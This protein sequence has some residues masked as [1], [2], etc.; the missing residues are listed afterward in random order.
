MPFPLGA[1]VTAQE[2][3]LD[4][5]PALARLRAAEP[6]SW[7]PA[8]DGWLITRRD[9][10]LAVMRD[11]EHF[12][13]DDPRFTTGR[14]VGPSMLT[15]DGDEH[16]RHRE[17]FAAPFRRAAVRERFAGFVARETDR[18]LDELEPAGNGE[19]RRGLAGPLAAAV[20]LH[21]LGLDETDAGAVLGWYDAIV[22]AVTEL[23]AGHELPPAGRDA[24]A[25]LA[26]ALDP[27]LDGPPEASL[28]AAAA[29]LAGGLPRERVVSNAAVLLFGG[30]ET[31]EGMIANAVLHLLERPD[32]RALVE[33]DPGLLVNAV[34]ESLRLEPAAAVVDRYATGDLELAGAAIARGDLVRVSI[35]AA[36]R[37]PAAFVEPDRF[38]VR[39][40]D[41]RRHLAFAH[42]PHV[43]LGMHLARLEAHTAVGRV[44]ARLP[45]L[46]LDPARHAAPRGLVFRKPPALR[47]L[48]DAR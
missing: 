14:V 19:L 21:A 46:R 9:L 36:N 38:D 29:T 2:L 37:D 18:L 44:L 43:C 23:S 48:W 8:L 15:L 45:G 39:R 35:T 41:A 26:R 5:H 1:A 3:E 4:P 30:I 24:A 25:A 20:T 42:G 10:A 11:P 22:A 28:V 6:V 40:P 16:R 12:T 13:V 31:T 32:Q 34:E 47:V 7:L 17:P 33:N 27:A